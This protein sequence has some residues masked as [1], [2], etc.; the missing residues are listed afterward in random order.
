M[1]VSVAKYQ[2]FVAKGDSAFMEKE[3]DRPLYV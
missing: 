3:I 1:K 2:G